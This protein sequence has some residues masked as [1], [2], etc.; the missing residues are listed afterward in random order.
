[1]KIVEFLK[2]HPKIE[3]VNYPNL[4]P[5]PEKPS[6]FDEMLECVKKLCVDFAFV[7]VDF[8][9]SNGKVYF[10]EM[11]FTPQSGT[12]KWEDEKQNELYGELIKLPEKSSLPERKR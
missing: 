6:N 5:A 1:M 10:G 7:R 3:S 9:S 11:T 2:N 12:G 8:Y 4:E